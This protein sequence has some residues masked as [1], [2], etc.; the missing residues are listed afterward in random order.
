MEQEAALTQVDESRDADPW[1]VAKR[2]EAMSLDAVL[3]PGP[4]AAHGRNC[5]GKREPHEA[6]RTARPYDDLRR[7]RHAIVLLDNG[8]CGGRTVAPPIYGRV[9]AAAIPRWP[10]ASYYLREDP[11]ARPNLPRPRF[12]P[13]CPIATLA[14]S[15]PIGK[16]FPC[17]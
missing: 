16:C 7:T 17:A 6:H 11:N 5:D 8:D 3:K 15:L 12:A 13:P 4:T 1:Q 10:R 2:A 14:C 9:W